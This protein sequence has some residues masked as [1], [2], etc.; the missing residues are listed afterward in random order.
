MRTPRP[1]FITIED[2]ETHVFESEIKAMDRT[3]FHTLL[4][5][6]ENDNTLVKLKRFCEGDDEKLVMID[7]LIFKL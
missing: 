7:N 4:G 2:G 5:F 3:Q 6:V 1:R